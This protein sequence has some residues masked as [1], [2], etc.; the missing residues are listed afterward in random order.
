M[1][2]EIA[3]HI[4]GMWLAFALTALIVAALVVRLAV[5]VARR[6]QALDTLRERTARATQV[7]GLATLAAGAAH[8]LSTPLSTIAVAAGELE[9]SLRADAAREAWQRDAVLI[10]TE[11]ARCRQILD[12]MS[13]GSGEVAG[14]SPR[15]ARLSEVM[16]T[17]RDRLRPDERLRVLIDV[18]EDIAVVWPV[19]VV[20]RAL[21]NLVQNALYASGDH[22][23]VQV[24]AR[25]EGSGVRMSVVDRGAGMSAQDLGR[26]GEPFFTT[27]PAGIGTGLG[28]FVA[29]A[30]VE[31]LGGQLLLSSTAGQ[32]TSATIV[33]PGDVIAGA[34]AIDV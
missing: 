24:I 14:E 18:G 33:L 5:A 19:A 32:G 17:V 13:A 4:R 6:D 30:T 29:R 12:A 31:Q 10:R 22:D 28:L 1:H 34:R 16:S 2:P 9:R 21:G 20:S 15:A 11:T 25:T 27:K 7:A 26:A 23:S 8:E 3:V